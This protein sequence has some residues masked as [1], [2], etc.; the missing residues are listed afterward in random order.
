MPQ[1][2]WFAAAQKVWVRIHQF[3]HYLNSVAR[4]PAKIPDTIIK[5]AKDVR[6]VMHGLVINRPIQFLFREH[7]LFDHRNFVSRLNMLTRNAHKIKR[8][9]KLTLLGV[10]AFPSASCR[11]AHP[12]ATKA[13]PQQPAVSNPVASV[14]PAAPVL[15]Q[16]SYQPLHT[17]SADF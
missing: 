13:T 12:V 5:R 8:N 15:A 4:G 10:L 11:T 6:R 7:N 1:E 9:A 2:I 16:T 14:P 17:A 3:H